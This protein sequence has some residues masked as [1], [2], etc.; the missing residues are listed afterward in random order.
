MAEI[1]KVDGRRVA[2]G[3]R[4]SVTMPTPE[5]GTYIYPPNPPGIVAGHPEVFTL[6]AFIFNFPELC[7]GPR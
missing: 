4:M 3:L 5:P 1:F 6:W 7:V 2:Q